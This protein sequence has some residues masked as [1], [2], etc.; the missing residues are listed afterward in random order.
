LGSKSDLKGLMAWMDSYCRSNPST[1]LDVAAVQL[2]NG[3]NQ[4]P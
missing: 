4:P 3:V 2:V 1:K